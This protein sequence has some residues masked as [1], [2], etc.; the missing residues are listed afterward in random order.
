[1]LRIYQLV[2]Y[3]LYKLYIENFYCNNNQN[4]KSNLS[5]FSSI[6]ST[7]V[8]KIDKKLCK[9]NFSFCHV[10]LNLKRNIEDHGSCGG[11]VGGMIN[12]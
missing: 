9:Y 8:C 6:L 12:F 1:M 7:V 3:K 10:I 4:Q 2:Q 5:L 11:V